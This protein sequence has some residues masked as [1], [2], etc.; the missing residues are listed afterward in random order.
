MTDSA[1]WEYLLSHHTSA[2]SCR[3]LR[4][5][6][7]GRTLHLCARCTG[8]FAG[9]VAGLTVFGISEGLRFPVFSLVVQSITSLLPLL[10]AWDWTSQALGQRE[11]TNLLRLASGGLL[12]VAFIDLLGLLVFRQFE[13]FLGG[14]LILSLYVAG[15][16]IILRVTGAWRR[17]LEEHFPG[18]DLGST[19]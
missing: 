9:I 2:R 11:S 1:S 10:A 12:G 3:T 19:V 14:L 8:Q 5:T 13:M 15:I 4:L 16:A 6:V 17:V 7:R 18:I